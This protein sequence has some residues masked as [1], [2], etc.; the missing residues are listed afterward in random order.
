MLCPLCKLEM[1]I[2]GRK[3]VLKTDDDGKTH[4]FLKLEMSCRNS[5]CPNFDKVV[6]TLE[7]EQPL[8]ID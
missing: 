2:K 8:S 3:N 4:L 5:K 7:N 6:D 1:K